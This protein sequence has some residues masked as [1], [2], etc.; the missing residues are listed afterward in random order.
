MN[1]EDY[2]SKLGWYLVTIPAGSKG[3]TSFGWQKPERAL[4][5]PD[6]ARKYYEQN[7]THN[8]GLLHGASGTCAI[9]IDHV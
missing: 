9:D 4:S 5:D 6:E 8:V 1:I 7:P 2:C 3:P